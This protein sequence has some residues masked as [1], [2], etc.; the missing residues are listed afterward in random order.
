MACDPSTLSNDARC[1]LC[2]N[3][4]QLLA[5]QT[6]LLCNLASAGG[7]AMSGTTDP[8]ADPGIPAAFY[9]NTTDGSFWAWNDASGS[10]TELLS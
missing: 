8:T 2:L 1:F 4:Q 9:F 5:I 7:G 10:W 6:Y 3:L